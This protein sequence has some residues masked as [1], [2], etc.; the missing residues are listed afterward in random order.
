MSTDAGDAAAAAGETG[1]THLLEAPDAAQ[2]ARQLTEKYGVDALALAEARA[3]RAS[4]IGDML[5]LEAWQAVIAATQRLLR[6]AR[7]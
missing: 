2:I 6:G 7:I 4:E 3:E 1:G 5:A